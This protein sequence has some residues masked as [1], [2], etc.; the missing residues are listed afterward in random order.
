VRLIVPLYKRVRTGGYEFTPVP[1]LQDIGVRCGERTYFFSVSTA[2]LPK[3]ALRV[4]FVRCPELYERDGIYTQDADEHL[5][6]ALLSR[7]ALEI[8][9]WTQWAPDVVHCNDWHTALIPL[10]LR[11]VYGWDKLFANTRTVLTIHNI[12]YQ[13]VVGSDTLESLGLAAE[14]RF[15]YQD[16]LEQGRVN[17]LKTGILYANAVTT[18]SRTYAREIQGEE[19][20]MGL[21]E[22]LRRRADH[23]FGIVNGVDYEEWNPRKDPL[24]P[25]AYSERDLRGKEA[26]KKELH[27]HLGLRYDA[28][29]PLTGIVSRLTAQKGLELLP[30]VLSNLMQH[31]DL[32]LVVLG[33]G[34]EK[35]EK[36]FA[37]A[38]SNFAGRVAFKNG[39][40]NR[41]AHWIEAASD[42][43]VMP[44]RYE[45]CGLN[46][47]YSLRYGTVPIVRR[48]GGL[49]DTVAP[50][51]RETGEGTGFLFDEFQ[52]Q[53]LQRAWMTALGA[54][55]DERAWQ[56][57]VQ[58]A[59][60]QDFSWEHQVLEY[61]DLYERLAPHP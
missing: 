57:L 23:L 33:S 14:K 58:N 34:E 5:R 55:R 25:H 22:L 12:G 4:F 18:V 9:Q 16:D 45:P 15:L 19:L 35:I 53:A 8:C 41:L 38:Q 11:T 54:F 21:H 29:A 32:R 50:W 17:F 56:R 37:W 10:Y 31:T 7:A 20:G 59:M 40:D 61:I 36:Y 13:G 24:I 6:F 48:T 26:N 28:E 60:A 39:F 46:Q 30:E 43:F 52:S 49:A 47:M 2:K 1:E 3:S 27:E 42:M 44:S 51:N